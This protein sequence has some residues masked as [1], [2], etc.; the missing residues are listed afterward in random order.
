MRARKAYFALAAAALAFAFFPFKSLNCPS[1][2]VRVID[3]TQKPV[4]G[5]RVRL[6]YQNYSAEDESHEVDAITDGNGEA[7]FPAEAL[8]ASFIRQCVFALLSAR[9]G[10]HASFGPHAHRACEKVWGFGKAEARAPRF[11]SPLE[12]GGLQAILDRVDGNVRLVLRDDQRRTQAD[13]IVP[14]PQNQ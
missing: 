2:H 6:S 9:A 1:W 13:G 3:G 14:R 12:A 10:V 7:T 5:M 11:A 8:R 4:A